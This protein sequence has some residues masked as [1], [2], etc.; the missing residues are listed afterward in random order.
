MTPL[1][2]ISCLRELAE[3]LLA[4]SLAHLTPTTQHKLRNDMLTVNAYPTGCGGLVFVG[5]PRYR[6]PA[7]P[8]LAR[9][10]EAA[11]KA[12]IVWLKFDAE[13]AVIDGLPIFPDATPDDSACG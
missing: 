13:A 8:D 7:E 12:G 5:A 2:L 1:T 6:M 9:I 10:F 11:E 4:L 3:P